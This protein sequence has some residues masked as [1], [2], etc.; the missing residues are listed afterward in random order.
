M[1]KDNFRSTSGCPT[2]RIAFLDV[3]QGDTI[4]VSSPNT[5]EAIVI[6]CVN[7]EA[8]LNYLEQEKIKYLR[9]VIITHLHADHYIDVP[10][11]LRNYDKV[12][13]LEP[14]EVLAYNF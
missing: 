5:R 6:D 12:A 4:V 7:A 13:G 2:I 8:V 10:A 14:C 1:S 9:G 11:L 3:G